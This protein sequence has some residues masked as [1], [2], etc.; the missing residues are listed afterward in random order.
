[1]ANA[2]EN[3]LCFN[4]DTILEDINVHCEVN[5]LA[6]LQDCLRRVI[7]TMTLSFLIYNVNM[8]VI[9]AVPFPHYR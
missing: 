9:Q 5:H 7:I 4:I 8:I 6:N 1:M 2:N 3:G